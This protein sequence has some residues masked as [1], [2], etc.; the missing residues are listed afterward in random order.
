MLTTMIVGACVLVSGIGGGV[1]C[2][3]VIVRRFNKMMLVLNC[4]PSGSV[5]VPI[6]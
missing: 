1:A 2:G 6:G 5:A 4:E 3:V